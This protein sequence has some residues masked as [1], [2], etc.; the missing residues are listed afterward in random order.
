MRFSVRVL[1]LISSLGYG[2]AER[3]IVDLSPKL[4]A[5]GLDISIASLSGDTPLARDLESCGIPVY[6]LDHHGTIYSLREIVRS[7][8]KFRQLVEHVRPTVIHSHLY[9]SDIM[10]RLSAPA[11]C[12]LISTL[13]NCD[14][15]WYQSSRVRSIGKT[16][17]DN[18]TGRARAVRFI[19]VSDD[20][21]SAAEAILGVPKQRNRVV[22]NGIML[23]R[24]KPKSIHAPRGKRIIQ[25]GRFYTQKNH[26]MALRAFRQ[27]LD[28]DVEAKLTLVGDGPLR[29]E[30]EQAASDLAI[31]HAVEF[32]GARNDVGNLLQEADIFW[33]TSS[34]EGLPVACIEAMACGLPSIVTSVG[35]LPGLISNDTVGRLVKSNDHNELARVTLDFLANPEL[36]VEVGQNARQHVTRFYSIDLTADRYMQAYRQLVEGQW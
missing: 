20:V 34:Y 17:L 10:S 5:R 1:Q 16:W 15:W 8:W 18:M 26:H 4:K 28:H 33:M 27:V 6:T 21:G 35:G 2:G 12:R 14:R 30:I 7:C 9:L 11:S 25:V 29:G 13:H 19:S 32:L 31:S 23:D 3:L 36:A 24:V 22:T